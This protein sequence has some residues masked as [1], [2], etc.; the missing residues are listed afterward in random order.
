M[1]SH[2]VCQIIC[3]VSVIIFADVNAIEEKPLAEIYKS[4]SVSFIPVQTIGEDSMPK[5]VFFEGAATV[6]TDA[7]KNIYISD[8]KANNIK[9]FDKNG[10]YIKSIGRKGQGPGE[11]FMPFMI[12]VTSDRL[13]VYDMGNWRLC[14]LTLEGEFIKSVGLQISQGRLLLMRALPGGEIA[15]GI[16]K[17]YFGEKDKPQE[18]FIS[19]YSAEL[20]STGPIYS[21]Q[22][23]RNKYLRHE[24]RL[25]NIIQPF[26][27]LVH[28][29]VSPDGKLI[30]GKSD[31]YEIYIY[32]TTGEKI[33]TF[34]HPYDPV[35]VT[36]QDKDI[37]FNGIAYSS[38]DGSR[39]G[40]PD[41]IK[42]ATDFPKHKSAFRHILVDSEGNI[43][44]CVYRVNREEDSKYFDAFN[45]EGN[46]L[47]SVRINGDEAFPFRA[48]INNRSFWWIK[49][50]EDGIYKI[51]K[52]RISE[53]NIEQR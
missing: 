46:F 48:K 7:K 33:H 28:W 17:A 12:S 36:D 24:G 9:K 5:G 21:Q 51:I 40:V 10:K 34:S 2:K 35:K 18:Y 39:K 41:H 31:K 3:V 20:E 49:A 43:L 53:E 30:I 50:D 38:S 16:E 29:D 27:P 19:I 45:P 4:G 26:S 23:W 44:I 22:I 15:A 42:K 37:F 32:S 47:G 1:R 8:Y 52:Y 13:I 11:F 14:T 25:T 6:V